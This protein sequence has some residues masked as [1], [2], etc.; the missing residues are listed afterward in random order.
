MLHLRGFQWLVGSR[1]EEPEELCGRKAELERLLK[2]R[3]RLLYLN[4]E[5]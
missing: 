1:I 5:W 2:A 3:D 4:L